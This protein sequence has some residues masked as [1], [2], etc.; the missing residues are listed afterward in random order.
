MVGCFFKIETFGLL[1]IC[2]DSSYDNIQKAYKDALNLNL[3]LFL[4]NLGELESR[5][6]IF[7]WY[8]WRTPG[9]WEI[10]QLSP[11]CFQQRFY[12]NIRPNLSDSFCWWLCLPVAL[13]Y[14]PVLQSSWKH[15]STL[16]DSLGQNLNY[17]DNT[18]TVVT[19]TTRNVL[20]LSHYYNSMYHGR[21]KYILQFLHSQI[22]VLTYQAD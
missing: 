1:M 14:W 4:K 17:L 16:S 5:S 7:S 10:D 2:F 21:Y 6:S 8:R 22:S 20:E 18:K 12:N 19:T 13:G 11:K 9:E 3:D 15:F